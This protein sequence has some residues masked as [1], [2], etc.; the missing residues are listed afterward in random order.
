M[1]TRRRSTGTSPGLPPPPAPTARDANPWSISSQEPRHAAARETGLSPFSKRSGDEKSGRSVSL[2]STVATPKRSREHLVPGSR[3][4]RLPLFAL[5]VPATIALAALLGAVRA[6]E[7]GDY[8]A[9]VGP[10][11]AVGFAAFVLLRVLRRRP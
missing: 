7:S 3:P 9:A 5:V 2:P 11:I 4:R 10:L 8:R 6:L 1:K